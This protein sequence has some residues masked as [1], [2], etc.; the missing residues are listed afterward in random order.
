LLD[1]LS[2]IDQLRANPKSSCGPS[3]ASGQDVADTELSRCSLRI[4]VADSYRRCSRNDFKASNT[5]QRVDHI[6][7]PTAALEHVHGAHPLLPQRIHVANDTTTR[8]GRPG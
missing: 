6:D 3:D 5:A 7:L 8:T 2:A 4:G 1:P